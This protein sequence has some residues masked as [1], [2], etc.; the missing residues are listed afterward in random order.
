MTRTFYD[1]AHP[2]ANDNTFGWANQFPEGQDQLRNRISTLTYVEQYNAQNPDNFDFASHYSYDLHGNVVDFVNQN[3]ALLDLGQ[4]QKYT[5]YEFDLVSGNVNEVQYQPGK[6]DEFYH[7]YVYDAD[8]R[9]TEAFTSR[10]GTIFERDQ[11]YFY[12]AHLPMARKETGEQQVQACDYVYALQGWLKGENSSLLLANND[13]GKDGRILTATQGGSLATSG[14]NTGFGTDAVGYTLGYYNG[15][16]KAINPGFSTGSITGFEASVANNTT[17]AAV[18]REL[19]NGNISHMTT[20]LTNADPNSPTVG[21][22]LPQLMSYQYDQ[23]NRIKNA[24]STT[25]VDALGNAWNSDPNMNASP[26]RTNYEFDGNGNLMKLGRFADNA[27]QMDR[28]TYEYLEENGRATNK[29]NHVNDGI[30]NTLFSN[31]IDDQGVFDPA[32]PTNNNYVYDNIGQLVS[33]EGETIERILWSVRNKVRHVLRNGLPMADGSFPPDLEFQYDA[34]GMRIWKIVKPRNDQGELLSQSA[35]K[36]TYYSCDPSGNVQAVYDRNLQEPKTAGDPFTDTYTVQEHH[37]YGTERAGIF[38]NG[39]SV[40]QNFT[41]NGTA[42]LFPTDGSG[43]LPGQTVFANVIRDP[44]VPDD[45]DNHDAGFGNTIATNLFARTLGQKAYELKNHLGNVLTTVSDRKIGN[46]S[47]PFSQVSN[48]TADL[49]SVSDYYPYGMQME[50][51][52]S[53]TSSRYRY[54]FQGQEHDDEVQGSGNFIQ[55]QYRVHDP[56]VGRFLSRD[57]LFRSYPH[58]SPYAFAENRVVRF[59]ELEGLEIG[60]GKSDGYYYTS[61]GGDIVP[62][63]TEDDD[64]IYDAAF[65]RMNGYGTVFNGSWV[66]PNI[67]GLNMA[68]PNDQAI[69]Y[70][71]KRIA[72]TNM[73]ATE[74]VAVAADAG[75][76]S[77]AIIPSAG[78]LIKE[79]EV[80]ASPLAKMWSKVKGPFQKVGSAIEQKF[81]GVKKFF[82]KFEFDFS[83]TNS[84][85]NPNSIKY[86]SGTYKAEAS[87]TRKPT[88]THGFKWSDNDA[89]KRAKDTGNPQGRFG[90]KADADYAVSKAQELKVGERRLIEAPSGTSNEI[91]MPDG[92]KKPATHIFIEVKPAGKTGTIHAFPV[93]EGYKITPRKGF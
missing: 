3:N 33:D 24:R 29:L 81:S 8:N 72:E 53:F 56:R 46:G 15:D 51:E 43:P 38:N 83:T 77:L 42:V 22:T 2:L 88:K 37:I 91:I 55:F 45:S 59:V 19:F 44:A 74:Y 17:V 86:R 1:D 20:A 50:G 34:N 27:A 31:D 6:F 41:T 84:G 23:L 87:L 7:R 40:T 26:Y 90:S 71:E 67:D 64:V 9:V 70:E 5:H 49:I 48:Y 10:D 75:L 21:E 35:W 30:T 93:E 61:K 54:G 82:K 16:Y 76:G 58:N 4:H 13:P 14:L 39:A 89:I 69:F 66:I 85:V 60:L 79:F 32:D 25:D 62:G 63:V 47:V 65:E 52:R 68:D 11:K 80:F 57:P 78:V 73:A 92:S 36:Y 18:D 12:Y 28:L